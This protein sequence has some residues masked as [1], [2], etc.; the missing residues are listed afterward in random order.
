MDGS[1]TTC[2]TWTRSAQILATLQQGAASFLIMFI[3]ILLK[4]A[5]LRLEKVS[6][7]QPEAESRSDC[8]IRAQDDA[9][10]GP[11]GSQGVGLQPQLMGCATMCIQVPI[12]HT[13]TVPQARPSGSPRDDAVMT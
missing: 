2:L 13:G 3:T 1:C 6:E 11:G 9:S 12:Y 4:S 7:V 8:G 5:R 10:L